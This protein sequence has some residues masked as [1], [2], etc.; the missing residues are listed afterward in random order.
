M[1]IFHAQTFFVKKV[2]PFND[3]I[4]LFFCVECLTPLHHPR[5]EKKKITLTAPLAR[6]SLLAET[7]LLPQPLTT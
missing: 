7:S 3:S 5:P 4:F 6:K 2:T 1:A